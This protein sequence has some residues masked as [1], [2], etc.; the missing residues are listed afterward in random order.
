M[1]VL[2]IYCLQVLHTKIPSDR[3]D[4]DSDEIITVHRQYLN[5]FFKNKK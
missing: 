4:T 5:T 3:S 2:D 1:C